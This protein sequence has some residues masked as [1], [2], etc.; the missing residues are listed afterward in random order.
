MRMNMSSANIKPKRK[1]KSAKFSTRRR[2]TA[3]ITA[4]P[5]TD[6]SVIR[7]LLETQGTN[8]F[9]L[10]EMDLPGASLSR[11]IWKAIDRADVVIAVLA[12]REESRNVL[13]EVGVAQGLQKPTL[14]IAADEPATS[15]AADTG[16]PYLRAKPNNFASLDFG[17]AQFLAA[18]HHDNAV[19]K[20]TQKETHPLGHDA[21]A[22][23]ARLHG[24]RPQQ[25]S[26]LDESLLQ[27][28]VV[29]AIKDSGVS[30]ISVGKKQGNAGRLAIA[31]R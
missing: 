24:I 1:Q 7:Q 17:L 21:D 15:L 3:F 18:P 20:P 12:G 25:G 28:I 2:R 23:L 16:I 31:A 8:V 29:D 30:T 14:I 4:P 9:A 27:N 19:P 22:L 6:T 26:R 10:A 11:L 13:I 5:G